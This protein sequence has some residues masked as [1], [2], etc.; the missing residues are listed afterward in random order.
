MPAFM[1]SSLSTSLKAKLLEWQVRSSRFLAIQNLP[2]EHLPTLIFFHG[3]SLAHTIRPL[4]VARALRE[5][6]Y[7]VEFAGV[8]P[9]QERISGEGFVVHDVVTLPQS[10]MDEYVGRCDYGFYDLDW[11]ER[12]VVSERE[13]IRQVSPQ[14][15]LCDMKPTAAISTACEGVD[16]AQ[17]CAAYTQPGYAFPI[18]LLHG[19][20]TSMGPFDE[21]IQQIS[22]ELKPHKV[23]YLMADVPE[24]HPPSPFLPPSWHYV[25]PLIEKDP[26]KGKAEFL[27][28][29]DWDRSLPLVYLTCGSSGRLPNYMEGLIERAA[30]APYRLLITTAGRWQGVSP[31]K[32]IQIHDFLPAAQILPHAALLVCTGG[33]GTIYQALRHGVPILGAPEHLDQEYHLNRV[34]DL[35]LGIKLD[36]ADFTPENIFSKIETLFADYIK[37]KQRCQEFAPCVDTWKGGVVAAD[38][39]DQYFTSRNELNAR[40]I[41][42]EADF[43]HY[44]DL[45]TPPELTSQHIRDLL[46]QGLLQGL[47]HKRQG[48]FLF[49]DRLSSWNWLYERESAFFE[50]D[51]RSLEKKRQYFFSTEAT[52]GKIHSR[53]LS[54]TYL[55][56]LV[57][58]AFPHALSPGYKALIFLPY[59]LLTPHQHSI[60]LISCT[61]ASLQE[62]L[63]PAFGFFYGCP[64]IRSKVQEEVWEFSYTC[65][66]TVNERRFG[67]MKTEEDLCKAD[68]EH[69]LE[70]NP[71]QGLLQQLHQTLERISITQDM[72]DEEKAWTLY[73]YLAE[74]KRYKKTL[75]E[76]RTLEACTEKVLGDNGGHCISL[77]YAFIGLCRSQGIPA[78]EATGALIGYPVEA[79]RFQ[80]GFY[81]EE[82]LCA[83]TWAEVFLN[84]KGWIPV[85]FHSVVIGEN[86]LTDGNVKS[87]ELKARIAQNT[88]PYREYY[89][90]NLDTHHIVFSNSAKK[91][92]LCIVEDSWVQWKP[93]NIPFEFS[94]YTQCL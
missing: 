21:Y 51:Y 50:N 57:Y 91:I 13:V 10:R 60:R 43:I 8:G 92:P 18:P 37:F 31:S 66:L 58:R 83:H 56:R 38:I 20:S 52:T 33:I 16:L 19:F 12:C 6:G 9:Y 74:S 55:L 54:Q 89:F 47:P 82:A 59:P 94:L 81:R 93:A 67:Q 64:I 17:L 85:E 86:A 46:R 1:F 29:V 32:N 68:Q 65:E 42:S 71:D 2:R 87:P 4:V 79:G 44:L 61:P 80:L 3:Y 75:D 34:R 7:P 76:Q 88:V 28:K 22:G 24:F 39:I 26:H 30:H 25:G 72:T 53:K 41:L 90:G 84:G 14:L 70:F 73:K 23:L 35:E 15:V 49:Y 77:A 27:E 11:I 62:Y 40:T 45:S 69:Y 48:K 63:I 36:R 5:K 78:H